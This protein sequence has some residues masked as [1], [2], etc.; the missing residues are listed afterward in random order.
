MSQSVQDIKP[1]S[2]PQVSVACLPLRLGS[3][4]SWGDGFSAPPHCPLGMVFYSFS[5]PSSHSGFSLL[6]VDVKFHKLIANLVLFYRKTIKILKYFFSHQPWL[7]E[8]L[9]L[10]KDFICNC[11]HV[12]S[13]FFSSP[14]IVPL[15]STSITLKPSLYQAGH[16]LSWARK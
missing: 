12:L 13:S 5:S 16:S 1:L 8:L 4:A 14:F 7:L 10:L 3:R 9:T 2:H 11:R 15:I 6:I